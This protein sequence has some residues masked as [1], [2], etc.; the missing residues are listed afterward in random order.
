MDGRMLGGMMSVTE[1][2]MDR[3]MDREF[4]GWI[5]VGAWMDIW[6]DRWVG[7]WMMDISAWMDL[8]GRMLAI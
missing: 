2:R 3:Y 7:A 4:Y 1:R 6:K 8:A 5:L